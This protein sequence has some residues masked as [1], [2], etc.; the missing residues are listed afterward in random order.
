MRWIRSRRRER[1][2]GLYLVDE[3]TRITVR[4]VVRPAA[5]GTD[6]IAND[7]KS[8]GGRDNR[9]RRHLLNGLQLRHALYCP[10]HREPRNRLASI[11]RAQSEQEK[12]SFFRERVDFERQ[13]FE[14]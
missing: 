7:Q 4:P 6:R 11:L 2:V 3:A 9:S 13:V 5:A 1:P 12:L 8:L 14:R 10:V